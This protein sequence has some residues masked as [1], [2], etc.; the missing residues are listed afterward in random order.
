MTPISSRTQADRPDRADPGS[1]ECPFTLRYC[2]TDRDGHLSS[3]ALCNLLQETAILHSE[4]VGLTGEAMSAKD[5]AWVLNRLHFRMRAFPSRKERVVIRTWAHEFGSLYAIREFEIVTE[6]LGTCG[7]ATSR[8]IVLQLS[9]RKVARLPEA[10]TSKYPTLPRRA[11]DDPFDRMQPH[12]GSDV[13]RPF[14]VRFSDVDSNLHANSVSYVD[15]CLETVPGDVLDGMRAH[16]ME[17]LYKRETSMGDDLLVRSVE[18]DAVSDGAR[19]FEHVVGL[20]DR[21]GDLAIARSRWT[22]RAT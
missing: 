9:R 13:E 2:D 4:S 15:W 12:E 16:E 14:H 18:L 7:V 11:L 8:W 21:P 22:A 10:I 20:R 19:Q 6:R 3:V 1:Y 5:F 17:I